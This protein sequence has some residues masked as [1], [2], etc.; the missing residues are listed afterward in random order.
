MASYSA[1]CF[2]TSCKSALRIW[3]FWRNFVRIGQTIRRITYFSLRHSVVLLWT[4]VCF[5]VKKSGDQLIC[6]P[7]MCIFCSD[8]LRSDVMKESS[9]F[10]SKIFTNFWWTFW[11]KWFSSHANLLEKIWTSFKHVRNLKFPLC[12]ILKDQ[13][14]SYF[15]GMMKPCSN[16]FLCLKIISSQP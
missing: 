12:L 2:A 16:I 7:A 13:S 8:F 9:S 15:N 1:G 6:V 5:F 3:L 11:T 10:L 4:W 14:L